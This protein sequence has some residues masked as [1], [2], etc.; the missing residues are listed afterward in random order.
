VLANAIATTSMSVLGIVSTSRK[1]I[2]AFESLD[3]TEH[4]QKPRF[5]KVESVAA[6]V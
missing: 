3:L 1:A 4:V 2:A 6:G 5:L